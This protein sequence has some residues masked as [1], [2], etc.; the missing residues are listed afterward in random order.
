MKQ[1]PFIMRATF[2]IAFIMLLFYALIVAKHFLII[3]V[4]AILFSYLIYPLVVR[5]EMLHFPKVLANL[6]AILLLLATFT[7]IIFLIFKQ[8][9]TLILD[10]P[11]LKSKAL[12]NIGLLENYIQSIS[13]LEAY[14]QHA[15]LK[16]SF[17]GLFES[18]SNFLKA[19][20]TATTSTFFKLFLL[21]VFMYYMLYYRQKFYISLIRFLPKSQKNTT[22]S[23]LHKISQMIQRYITGVFTVVALLSVINSLG[24]YIVGLEY[25][26]VFGIIS[27]FFN[28]IP[29][30]GTWIGAAFPI[31]FAMLTG[32]TF[33]LTV[34]VIILFIII[35]FTE[36][37]ILTPNITGS[38]IDVNP[39]ITILSIIIGGMVWGVAGMFV[40]LPIVAT[41]K[42][43]FEH[44]PAYHAYA[45][46]ISNQQTRKASLRK[47]RSNFIMRKIRALFAK[48]EVTKSH[49]QFEED[50]SKEDKK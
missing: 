41:L 21:P 44:F 3:I 38:F 31:V 33:S 7:G 47:K 34:A 46:L 35:Q 40:V 17:N 14:K 48:K 28:F 13:G 1:Y 20:F 24:L 29:Y 39:F 30:F 10:L 26:L 23:I 42:I 2:F 11:L 37:N 18:G 16:D 8:V 15:W 50:K 36:N 19:T 5:L 27:A 12:H 9:E 32:D 6:T 25:A 22:A 4:L 45:Y 43:I 49:H